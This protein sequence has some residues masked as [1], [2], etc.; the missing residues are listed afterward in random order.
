LVP[1]LI[2]QERWRGSCVVFFPHLN[3]AT[4]EV[5][6]RTRPLFRP[7]THHASPNAST[8]VTSSAVLMWGGEVSAPNGD[9]PCLARRSVYDAWSFPQAIGE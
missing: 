3:Q 8:L 1:C 7:R 6:A 9:R 5:R 4:S 2:A